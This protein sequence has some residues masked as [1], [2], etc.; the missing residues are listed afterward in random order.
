MKRISYIFAMT[1]IV[2]GLNIIGI[3]KYGF[4]TYRRKDIESIQQSDSILNLS[5][6]D[7]P[8]IQFDILVPAL[9][10]TTTVSWF[11]DNEIEYQKNNCSSVGGRWSVD[12]AKSWLQH[13]PSPLIGCNFI[14]STAINQ[15][16]MWSQRSF[17]IVTIKR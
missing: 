10:S 16:E 15:I 8:A 11:Y 9:S 1:F 4:A 17:D 6:K 7:E 12:A 5:N 3:H 13:L 2:F 14:P